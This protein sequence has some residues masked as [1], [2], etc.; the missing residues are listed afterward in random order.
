MFQKTNQSPMQ[1][2]K[3]SNMTSQIATPK[4][5][6]SVGSGSQESSRAMSMVIPAETSN[7]IE[8]YDRFLI[9]VLFF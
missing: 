5:M 3:R 8:K 9:Q 4:G 1:N 6:T 2:D 7:E